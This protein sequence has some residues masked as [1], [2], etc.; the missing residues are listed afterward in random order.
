[1]K[2][3][4]FF[5]NNEYKIKEMEDILKLDSIQI[6][7]LKNMPKINSPSE[8]G[9]TFRENAFIKSNFGFKKF[10]L[11]CF[12]D[13]SG[14]CISA[15]NNGPGIKSK[16]YIG[17]YKNH[18]ETFDKIIQKIKYKKDDLAFFQTSISFSYKKNSEKYFDGIVHGRISKKPIGG[19]GFD[20]DPIFIPDGL[21][22]TYAEMPKEVKNSISHRKKALEKLKEYLLINF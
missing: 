21:N 9:K 7:T 3:I 12:A 22:M 18:T 17:K 2:K 6:L 5:S 10:G 4:I 16:R 13:D 11:P 15:L 1:M 8:I 19:G 14:I 20:Y